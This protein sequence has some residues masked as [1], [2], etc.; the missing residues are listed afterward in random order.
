MSTMSKEK[1]SHKSAI[2]ERMREL[3]LKIK[4]WADAYYDKDAPVVPDSAYDD[5]LNELR[6]LEEEHPSLVPS[7]SPTLRVGAA[8]RAQFKK[9]THKIPMLSL[10]NVFS[11]EDLVAYFKKAARHLDQTEIPFPILCEEKMDGLAISLHYSKGN[12]TL[13]TTRGDGVTGEDVTENLKTIRDIPLKLQG[14]FPNE[15]EVRG[16]VYMELN[17]FEKLNEKLRLEGK[18]FLQTL[19]M[20]QQVP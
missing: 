1:N 4:K 9:V 6:A 18:R 11:A 13:G 12:F 16:E 15:L 20:P 8:P 7:D 14:K 19:A 2:S 17:A 10:A 5:A 3:S